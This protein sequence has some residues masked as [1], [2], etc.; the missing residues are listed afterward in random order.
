M[1]WNSDIDDRIWI[2]DR[3]LGIY[4]ITVVPQPNAVPDYTYSLE[5]TTDEET[6]TLAEN[7]PISDIP[8]EPYI[9]R[10]TE[11]DI[12]QIIL[13][14][15]DFDPDT[16]NLKS[17][18]KWITCYIEL[19]ESYDMGDIALSTIKLNDEVLAESRPT[20]IGDYDNDGLP[21]LMVKFDMSAVQQILEVGNEVKITVSGELNEGT[22]FEGSDKIRVIDKGGKK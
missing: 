17:K 8:N 16:L 9:I 21:D 3:K 7:V 2:T 20:E 18:G 12:I 19:P 1:E 22:A 13:A 4:T 14:T 6:I 11:T 5:V 15:I 10:S